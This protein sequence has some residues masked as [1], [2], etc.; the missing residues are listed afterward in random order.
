MKIE[1]VGIFDKGVPNNERITLKVLQDCNLMYY[2]VGKTVYS[3]PN[4]ISNA[5]K[6]IFWFSP[7]EVKS[8]DYIWLYTGNGSEH[9]HSNTSGTT[10]HNF[11]WRLPKTIFH[12]I[13][14][15]AVLFENNNWQTSPRT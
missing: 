13:D 2:S 11:Y 15:C 8:G 7:R 3:G 6:E 14:D 1:I 9:T 10:T 5:L 12:S 4:N